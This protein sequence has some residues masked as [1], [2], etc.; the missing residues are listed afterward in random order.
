L[1]RPLLLRGYKF[2]LRLYVLVTSL[3][4]MTT[5]LYTEGLARFCSVPYKTPKKGNMHNTQMHLTNYAING[6]AQGLGSHQIKQTLTQV[7]D[8]MRCTHTLY[9]YTV[10][11]HRY[12]MKC[13]ATARPRSK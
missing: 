13:D 11:T 8:E 10:L 6:Q 12:S 3:W 9:S 2:D 4:P 7:L 5:Y 1:P